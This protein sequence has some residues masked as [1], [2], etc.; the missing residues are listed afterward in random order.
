MGAVVDAAMFEFLGESRD[1]RVAHVERQFEL[2]RG[3]HRVLLAPCNRQG[4]VVGDLGSTT[5]GG[6]GYI[7]QLEV[8]EATNRVV[9][10]E[11]T[12]RVK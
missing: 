4:C 6:L 3:W 12:N 1:K 11:L 9:A 10:V 2:Q 5:L 8:V 7:E